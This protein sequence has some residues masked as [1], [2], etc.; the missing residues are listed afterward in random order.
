S[1]VEQEMAQVW[2]QLGNRPIESL[3][4]LPPMTD[5]ESCATIDVLAK[6][7][8]AATF[9]D[10]NL[11]CLIGARMTNLSLQYGN[12]P[13]SCISYVVLGEVLGSY[14]GDY[15]AGFRFGQLG[16]DLLAQRGP[17]RFDSRVTVTFGAFANPA[18]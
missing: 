8:P 11:S 10:D 3:I 17:R 4:D 16:L 9:T 13:A 15:P 1:E 6:I 18:M 7:L 2:H 5:P 14:F 12:S